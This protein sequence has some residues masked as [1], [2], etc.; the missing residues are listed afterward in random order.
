MTL[1]GFQICLVTSDPGGGVMPL[2]DIWA[3]STLIWGRHNAT[4][5][6]LGGGG[7]KLIT[8]Y[9]LYVNYKLDISP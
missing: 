4:G 1:Y 7:Q 8:S 6:F 3:G 5:F 2:Y 9:Y